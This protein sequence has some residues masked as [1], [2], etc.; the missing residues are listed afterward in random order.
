MICYSPQPP[1]A[2]AW[3]EG[4]MRHGHGLWVNGDLP[5]WNIVWLSFP[6]LDAY[7]DLSPAFISISTAIDPH[8][9][10]RVM[11]LA[12]PELDD[13]FG[14]LREV[15]GKT[16]EEFLRFSSLFPWENVPAYELLGEPWE[17]G[18]AHV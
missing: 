13:S 5:T 10:G 7:L 18:R 16:P 15:L 6:P 2:Y 11:S 14:G 3:Y 9:F 17:I 1:E 12:D 8:S 4:G